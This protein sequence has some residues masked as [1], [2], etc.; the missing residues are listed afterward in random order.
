MK[1]FLN[2]RLRNPPP[3]PP[4]PPTPPHPSQPSFPPFQPADSGLPSASQAVNVCVHAWVGSGPYCLPV[5]NR[6]C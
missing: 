2:Q 6:Q 4:N 3:P 1:P 5:F